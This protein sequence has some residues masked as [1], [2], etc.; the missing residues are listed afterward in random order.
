MYELNIEQVEQV[1]GGGVNVA[2]AVLSYFVA[3]ALDAAA[4]ATAGLMQGGGD[5]AAVFE[6]QMGA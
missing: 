6:S 4:S 3:K 2:Q 5:I 1:A